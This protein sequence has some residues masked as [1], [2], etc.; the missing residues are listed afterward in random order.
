MDDCIFCK[1]AKGEI[2]S[3]R[4]IE[5]S[6]FVAFLD[7][8]PSMVGEVL[9]IPKKHA[10]EYIFDMS[11]EFISSM[12]EF[13]KIVSAALKKSFDCEKIGL[14][15]EGLEVNHVHMK[16]YPLVGP[17]DI[18]SKLNLS[19]DELLGISNKIKSNL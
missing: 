5:N 13:S 10:G 2:P 6:E 14:V 4:I 12:F 18:S 7:I 15:F 17:L 1:V 16:L 3:H 11:E 9:V 8:F 19:E